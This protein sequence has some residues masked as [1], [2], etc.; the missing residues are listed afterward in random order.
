MSV[1]DPDPLNKSILTSAASRSIQKHVTRENYK[2]LLTPLLT[3]GG[4]H[5]FCVNL[6]VDTASVDIMELC[7]SLGALY[8]DTVNEP[9]LGFYSTSRRARPSARIM[10][11]A[12]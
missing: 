4:G 8:I 9:W 6:S 12:S 5:G 7:R 10:R 2:E 11:C 3:K 1:I